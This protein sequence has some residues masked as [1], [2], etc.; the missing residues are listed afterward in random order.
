MSGRPGSGVQAWRR[1]NAATEWEIDA[2]VEQQKAERAAEWAALKDEA[3][4]QRAADEANR[5]TVEEIRAAS[6]VRDRIG[7]HRVV[8]VNGKSVTVAT[9]YSW[10]DRIPFD[11]ILEARK[12]DAA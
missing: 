7:W 1:R 2:A 8:R 5:P 12:L 10:T 6:F 9:P 4:A 11:R 3:A